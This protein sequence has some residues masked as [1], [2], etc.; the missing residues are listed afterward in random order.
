ETF[1]VYKRNPVEIV[2]YLIGL[3]RLD[4]HTKYALEKNW[5][6]TVDGRRIRVYS[7]MWT[8][9][10][11]WRM[12]DLLGKGAT[13]APIILATDRTQL[14]K[15]GGDKSAWPVYQSIG[16]ISK[17][18]RRRPTQSAMLLVGYIPVAKLSWITNDKERSRKQWEVY[19]E[20]MA[21]ILEPLKNASVIGVE[22]RC[23]D[24]GVR[25]VYPIF[26][27]HI[28]DWPEQCTVACSLSS[29]CPVCVVPFHERGSGIPGRLRTKHQT[30]E[31]LQ[32]GQRGCVGRRESAGLR[33]TWP[34]W[35]DLPWVN[36]AA[37]IM[38]DLL[39]QMH[40]GVIKSHIVKWWTRILGADELDQRFRAMTH[41]AGLRHFHNG[42]TTFTQW[43]GTES[44]MVARVLLPLVAGSR[45]SD[46]VGAARC[47]VD[48]L[49]RSHAPQIDEDDVANMEAD[50]SEFHNYKAIFRQQQV[51]KT[52]YGWNGIP[53]IHMISHY[54]HSTREMGTPDGYNT[55]GP[56]RLHK[57]YVK[58]YYP[59]TSR[60][61]AEPQLILL[62]QRQEAWGILRGELERAGVVSARK[63]RVR[64]GQEEVESTYEDM[65]ESD[66]DKDRAIHLLS[67]YIQIAA[68][69]T[70]PK[71]LGS[72]IIADYGATDFIPAL[73]RY[74]R[75]FSTTA[76]DI[77]HKDMP[78]P[79]WSRFSLHHDCLPFAPLV[80]RKIDLVRA[81]PAVYDRYNRQQR[82]ARFD[83]VLLANSSAPPGLHH[84]YAVR[85]HAI[86]R[87]PPI[88]RDLPS[89]PLLYI[90]PFRPFSASAPNPHQL[91][92]ASPELDASHRRIGQIVPLSRVRMTCHLV[93][94]FSEETLVSRSYRFSSATDLL[95]TASLFYLSQHSSHYF[96]ALME[97]WH[98]ME[99]QRR[100]EQN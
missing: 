4:K 9:D 37:T 14:S 68:A 8:G 7:E 88:F 61:N 34:F 18:I 5:T 30:Q 25:R 86:F 97:H 70:H 93:P 62:L 99:N 96:F 16:N 67:P 20:S 33:E 54:P 89:E 87:I 13:I 55:E 40:K 6:I 91:F 73:R 27:A 90:Q 29:R 85:V 15:L 53:K 35:G 65:D 43:T 79:V 19:H 63:L 98:R 59:F 44:K 38:P 69:P 94:K 21:I 84:Y 64:P 80:G 23:A 31:L 60:V 81:S 17:S 26:A 12:Q 22:M 71:V 45:P 41:Y 11:W 42:I 56:E 72:S 82:Q 95:S 24:G 57:D 39:H 36:G 100:M 32:D 52:K 83:T 58:F 47:L 66:E 76:A 77:I 46:A 78:F 92:T 51:L 48:F 1:V 50:L 3:E 49:Y 74:V 10:W 2:R 75:Q 28:G